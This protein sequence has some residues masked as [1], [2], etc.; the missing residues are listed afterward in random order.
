MV[1]KTMKVEVSKEGVQQFEKG[2][3][4]I[5]P[6]GMSLMV[7]KRQF[8]K[9]E[10]IAKFTDC[11]ALFDA[12][13]QAERTLASAQ[14]ALEKASV[15]I[16]TFANT[17]APILVGMVGPVDAG[18]CGIGISKERA[19]MTAEALALRAERLRATRGARGTM[20]KRQKAAIHGVVP[21]EDRPHEW[22]QRASLTL[23]L[24][25]ARR[26]RRA[27]HL[28]GSFRFCVLGRSGSAAQRRPPSGRSSG[29]GA[30]AR[31]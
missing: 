6:D 1:A 30:Q 26:K 9:S 18:Q 16:D 7:T 10:L 3:V 27:A 4:K 31:P 20:G 5:I 15:E 12:V 19:P 29:V 17:L 11:A 8:T 2:L 23:S 13:D 14:L 25:P 24:H 21:C 28:G 22:R